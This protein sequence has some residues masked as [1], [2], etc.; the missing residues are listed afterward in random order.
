MH[1]QGKCIIIYIKQKGSSIIEYDLEAL[2]VFCFRQ[3]TSPMLEIMMSHS[4][5]NLA[6]VECFFPFFRRVC[7]I[8][9]RRFIL[10]RRRSILTIL[11][12]G[13]GYGLLLDAEGEGERLDVG[14]LLIN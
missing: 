7:Q 12:V 13:H 5:I 9:P 6:Y 1:F 10:K 3:F 8:K 11:V 14:N 2:F 4:E